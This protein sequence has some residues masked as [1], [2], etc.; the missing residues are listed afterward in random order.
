M[1]RHK[2]LC[3]LCLDMIDT[4][5]TLCTAAQHLIERGA[6]AVCA[7]VTHGVFSPPAFERINK[8]VIEQI[9]VTD[10]ISQERNLELCKKL[11][12]L[13]V[14]PLLADT[15]RRIHDEDSVSSLFT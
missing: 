5:G 4:A 12:V 11:H 14:A 2:S 8:S 13:S 7:C 6:V 9:V 10:S 1:V 3:F 15:I